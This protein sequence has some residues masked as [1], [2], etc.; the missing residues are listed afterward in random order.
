MMRLDIMRVSKVAIDLLGFQVM[1]IVGIGSEGGGE[2]LV[3]CRSYGRVHGSWSQGGGLWNLV[4][5]SWVC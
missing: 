2:L 5:S 1:P 3:K 4:R